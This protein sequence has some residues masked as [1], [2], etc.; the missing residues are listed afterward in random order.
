MTVL[1]V[2][3]QASLTV[4]RLNNPAYVQP[5]YCRGI[6]SDALSS[7]LE[8]FPQANQSACKR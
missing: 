3:G 2:F 6:N 8:S 1:M 4:E 7:S 5:A